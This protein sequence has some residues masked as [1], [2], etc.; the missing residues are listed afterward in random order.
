MQVAIYASTEEGYDRMLISDT[1]DG[2]RAVTDIAMG[3]YGPWIVKNFKA[4]DRTRDGRFRFQILELSKDGK[5]FKLYQ[6]AINTA[7]PYSVPERLTA[8]VEKVAGPY[9][10]VDDPWAYMDGWMSMELYIEQLGL[11]NDWWGKATKYVLENEEWDLGFSWVGTIDHI[12]HV[13]YAG[14]EPNPEYMTPI[15]RI[16]AWSK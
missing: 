14:I 11:H 3:E 9:M 12:K 5:N 15:K 6:S 1:K 7:E 2:S 13:L 8:E 16:G 4:N 10:E